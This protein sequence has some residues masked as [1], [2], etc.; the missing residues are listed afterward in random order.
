MGCA[1]GLKE[2]AKV[3][4]LE[5]VGVFVGNVIY[6][7]NGCCVVGDSDRNDAGLEHAG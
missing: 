3:V 2:G 5:G 7:A 4:D 1:D 6:D